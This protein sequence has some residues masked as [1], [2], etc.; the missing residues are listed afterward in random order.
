MEMTKSMN[1]IIVIA[2][3][4]L[5]I[6]FLGPESTVKPAGYVLVASII[7]FISLLVIPWVMK[8]FGDKDAS[9]E[10]KK[11]EQRPKDTDLIRNKNERV[12]VLV[13]WVI[14][15]LLIPTF[16]VQAPRGQH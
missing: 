13:A 6:T 16:G 9:S 12:A 5:V 1:K 11:N 7:V 4:A 10:S 14:L 8:I 15:L 3:I 2:I